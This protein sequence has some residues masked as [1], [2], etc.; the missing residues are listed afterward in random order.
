[1]LKE[2]GCLEDSVLKCCSFLPY[3]NGFAV[4]NA[5][6]LLFLVLKGHSVLSEF[7]CWQ[8]DTSITRLHPE[9]LL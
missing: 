3:L 9:L 8:S 5:P 4:K 1:M 6:S 2:A 7:V